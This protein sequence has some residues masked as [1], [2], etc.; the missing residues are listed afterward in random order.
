LY[1]KILASGSFT[2]STLIS[3]NFL[4][5]SG[6]APYFSSSIFFIFS[7]IFSNNALAGS[8]LFLEASSE[9]NFLEKS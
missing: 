3:S 8:L 9:S 4:S 5:F 7:F 1:T 6:D 2:S